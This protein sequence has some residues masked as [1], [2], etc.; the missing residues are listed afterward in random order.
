M[1]VCI[2][3]MKIKVI[4]YISIFLNNNGNVVFPCNKASYHFKVQNLTKFKNSN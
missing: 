3:E 2:K 4:N 1:H